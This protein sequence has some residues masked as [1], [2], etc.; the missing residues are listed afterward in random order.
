M[1]STFLSVNPAR[2]AEVVGEFASTTAAEVTAAIARAAQAQRA[3]AS[4]PASARALIV[5]GLAHTFARQ[6]PQLAPLITREE[7]KTLTDSQAEVRKAVEQFHFAAQLCYQVE[8]TTYPA[9]QPGVFTYSL[10]SPIG[11]VVAITPWN[12]PVSLAARKIG[13]ALAAGNAVVFKPSPVTAAVGAAVVELM[14]DA[15]VPP[16]L[17]QLVQ[18]DGPEAMRTM[19]ASHTVRAISLTGSSRVGDAVR[20][21]G[22]RHA[23]LQAELSGHNATVVLADADLDATAR[24]VVHGGFGLTGQACTAA[25]RVLVDRRVF[26]DFSA[27]VAGQTVTIR[28]GP[29]DAPGVSC[30]PV[31]TELQFE[32]ISALLDSARAAGARVVAEGT[33]AEDRD[34]RGWFIAPTVLAGLPA[35]H[36]VNRSEVF[37]PLLSLVPIDGLDEALEII[38]GDHFGL[39]NAIHTRDLAAAH[40]FAAEAACG[41]VKINQR[42]TGNGIA[43]PFGGWKSSSSGAFPEGGVQALD[44][45]TETKAVYCQY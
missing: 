2:P 26:D 1:T 10:R 6:I 36:D 3:W 37:G 23:R 28:C 40:R 19:V 21:Q 43:P 30:G 45:F 44:F 14:R 33:L 34:P 38:N 12:F 24:E 31:A 42:T 13:P 35:E 41:L 25:A 29:G 4:R 5:G 9:E 11:V 20:E 18:G 17:V 7:G 8:G 32:R 39:A 27:R 16:D 15:G 22:H